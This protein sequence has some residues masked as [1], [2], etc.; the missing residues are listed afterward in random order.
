[1]SAVLQGMG[2]T[3][4]H[5]TGVHQDTHHEAYGARSHPECEVVYGLISQRTADGI[6]G[7]GHRTE[8]TNPTTGS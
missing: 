7:D 1:M 2:S 8:F 6:A 5:M 3:F 4:I